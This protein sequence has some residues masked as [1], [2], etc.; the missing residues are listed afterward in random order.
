MNTVTYT[1]DPKSLVVKGYSSDKAA[2][3]M[4]NG[5]AFFKNADEL[6]AD[7]NVTGPLLVNAYNEIAD[8]PVKKFSDNK[9]AA[10]RFMDAIADIHVTSTRSDKEEL[11]P[12]IFKPVEKTYDAFGRQAKK[13]NPK[14]RG[15]FAG[16]KIKCLIDTNPRKEGTRGWNN[17][18][19]FLGHGTISYEEFVELAEGHGSTKGGC[20]EDLAHDIKKGRVE[21][22][23][24]C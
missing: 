16:K 23:D 14:S 22:I 12:L 21:I 8:K 10:K 3:S 9:T 24:E 15:S 6:L 1:L 20:R 4:G 5:V 13:N 7:R 17:F 19:L 18:S 2:R 11:A